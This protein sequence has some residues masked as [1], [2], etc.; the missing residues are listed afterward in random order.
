[1]AQAEKVKEKKSPASTGLLGVGEAI[2]SVL[3]LASA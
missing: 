2:S 1:V 3:P